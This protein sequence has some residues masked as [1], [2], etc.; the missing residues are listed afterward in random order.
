MKLKGCRTWMMYTI[1]AVAP[2]HPTDKVAMSDNQFYDISNSA[3]QFI[4]IIVILIEYQ[5][6]ILRS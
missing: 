4:A 2:L 1:F 5:S 3:L 6:G